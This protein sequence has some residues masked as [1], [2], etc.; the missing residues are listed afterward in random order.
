V[1]LCRSRQIG[2]PG[3]TCLTDKIDDDPLTFFDPQR[4]SKPSRDSFGRRA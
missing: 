1:L 2:L 4:I 3:L